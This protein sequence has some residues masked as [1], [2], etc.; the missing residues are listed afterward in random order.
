MLNTEFDILKRT[1]AGIGA[2]SPKCEGLCT[3]GLAADSPMALRI[4]I[5]IATAAQGIYTNYYI[6]T[7]Y[8]FQNEQPPK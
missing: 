8:S 6:L 3:D 1:A 5:G 2:E 7:T 4:A